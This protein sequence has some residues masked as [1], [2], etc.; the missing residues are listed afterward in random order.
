MT[1]AELIVKLSIQ[2]EKAVGSALNSIR[3]NLQR[4]GQDAG[5][6]AFNFM[7]IHTAFQLLG[8]VT[9]NMDSILGIDTAMAYDSQVRALG[10]Y[11][12]NAQELTAQLA[13]LKQIAKLPGIDLEGVRVGVANLEAAGLSAADSERA[14]MGFGNALALVGRGKDQLHGVIVALSQIASKGKLMAQEVNQLAERTPQIRMILQRAFGTA[15][16]EKI[17][18]LGLEGRDAIRMITEELMKLP[19]MTKGY[20]VTW[21][22]FVDRVKQATLPLGRGI[23]DMFGNAQEGAYSLMDMFEDA[24]RQIGEVFTAIAKANIVAD[25]LK[26]LMKDMGMADFQRGFVT[27][28]AY[29][30]A[31]IQEFPNIVSAVVSDIKQFFSDTAD[32]ISVFWQNL[33]IDIRNGIRDLSEFL[34]KMF[35][36]WIK[37]PILAHTEPGK[38]IATATTSM[39]EAGGAREVHKLYN[40]RRPYQTPGAIG[41]AQAWARDFEKK[42]LANLGPQGL[43]DGII[44]GM[45][46]GYSGQSVIEQTLGKIEKN[47]KDSAD[48]LQ[49]RRE[50]LGGGK[51]GKLGFNAAEEYG[52]RS[53]LNIGDFVAGGGP[54]PAGTDLERALRRMFRDEARK[55]G[56]NAGM[57]R[58]IV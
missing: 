57:N 8:T 22:N 46:G 55:S 38:Q 30:L 29:L 2:G 7:K 53:S 10:A 27:F 21:E 6:A 11:S 49:L 50:T 25:V 35:D 23:L 3:T 32:A 13:R 9:R 42:I 16:T 43:P 44:Y 24:T 31:Y 45:G 20:L 5:N 58:R 1:V 15:D 4:A 56:V 37:A 34:A 18:D 48:A 36:P 54:I 51:L 26:R 17:Q 33:M 14:I 41:M 47:T 40:V 52:G 28:M 39:T 19:K 12:A